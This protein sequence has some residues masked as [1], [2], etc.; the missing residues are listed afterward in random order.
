M[1]RVVKGLHCT[2]LSELWY[3]LVVEF[4]AFERS[5][6]FAVLRGGCPYTRIHAL[7]LSSE[8]ST[9]SVRFALVR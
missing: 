9:K 6:D 8:Q 7:S 3:G 4:L 1:G 5:G 2:P